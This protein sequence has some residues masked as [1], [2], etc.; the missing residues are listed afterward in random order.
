LYTAFDWENESWFLS[1][2]VDDEERLFSYAKRLTI[3]LRPKL[4]DHFAFD[5]SAGY[6]FDRFFFTGEDFDDRDHDRI[7]ISDGEFVGINASMTW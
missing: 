3:G 6:A 1:D 7:D 2:R 5:V 4:G